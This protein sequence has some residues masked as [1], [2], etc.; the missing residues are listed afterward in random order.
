M[1]CLTQLEQYLELWNSSSKT[2]GSN[3]D[4]EQCLSEFNIEKYIGETSGPLFAFSS[5]NTAPFL[6]EG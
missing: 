2:A 6:L 1:D 4:T 3:C 5:E